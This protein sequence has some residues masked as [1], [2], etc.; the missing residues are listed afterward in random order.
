MTEGLVIPFLLILLLDFMRPFHN[1]H[2]IL[3]RCRPAPPST[4][5]PSFVCMSSFSS[6]LFSPLWVD[7]PLF[8]HFVLPFPAPFL[9]T[10]LPSNHEH[11]LLALAT[12]FL[13]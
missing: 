2:R 10:S 6:A 8:A 4:S 13:L 7:F 11:Q 1:L 9:S 3:L 12:A 5:S